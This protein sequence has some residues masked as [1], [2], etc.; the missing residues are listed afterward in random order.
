MSAG[1]ACRWQFLDPDLEVFEQ[2]L[3]FPMSAV[4]GRVRDYRA[5]IYA[6][7]R[8]G[9]GAVHEGREKQ[10]AAGRHCAHAA[11]K[12]LGYAAQPVLREGRKPVWPPGWCGSITHTGELAAAVASREVLALGIDLEDTTRMAPRLY[13]RLFS[14]GETA[15]IEK[16]G[17]DAATVM[18]SAK[19][20]AY[21]AINAVTGLYI[22][23]HEA[24]IELDGA[25]DR[26]RFHYVGDNVANRIAAPV[27][28]G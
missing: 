8:E 23:F 21:K 6:A 4:V 9:L 15:A 17:G 25:S 2:S 13:E 28:G 18:F 7:E 19:E 22:G 3:G 12:L 10:F 16:L 24:E 26:F 14:R 5:E 20:A 27:C 11:Q 1:N